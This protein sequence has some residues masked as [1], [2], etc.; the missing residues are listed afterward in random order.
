[1]LARALML[2]PAFI[3]ADEPVSM[4]DVSV[5]AGVLNVMR[6]VGETLGLTAIYISHDLALVRML[7]PRTIVMYL[8][9]IVEDGPTTEVIAAPAHPYTRALVAAVPVPRVDQPRGPLP[10]TGMVGDARDPPSGCRFRDR[11]PLAQP[12][13]AEA[14]PPLRTIAPGRRAACHLL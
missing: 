11:C 4:L 7:A 8:G 14:V 10:I 2:E 6:E 13:C 9:A 1:V 3:V 5:R 12:R